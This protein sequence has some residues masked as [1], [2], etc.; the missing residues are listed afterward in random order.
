MIWL[1]TGICFV[2]FGVGVMLMVLDEYDCGW[3][4]GVGIIIAVCFGV[5]LIVCAVFGI[6]FLGECQ[7]LKTVDAKIEMCEEENT[8]IE[9]RIDAVVK[10]YQNYE[11]DTFAEFSPDAD[12]MTMIYLYPELKSDVLVQE[13]IS[14]YVSNMERIK[15]LKEEKING[16]V[17]K[18]WLYFGGEE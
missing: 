6:V 15:E 4:F 14:L 16:K 3:K 11:S 9:E 8:K 2:L 7:A 18:W 17:I 13:Q 1:L 5:S 10:G 12:T